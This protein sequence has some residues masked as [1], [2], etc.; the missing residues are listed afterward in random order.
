MA[1]ADKV[2]GLVDEFG[3]L[4]NPNA[5]FG[6]V[7]GGMFTNLRDASLAGLAELDL[8]GYAIGGLSVGE[9]KAEMQRI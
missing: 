4:Q 9:P 8:P 3:R 2:S 1:I 5:L 6:I 7:Q